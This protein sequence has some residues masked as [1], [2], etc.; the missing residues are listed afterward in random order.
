MAISS[1]LRIADFD[2]IK[3]NTITNLSC[4]LSKYMHIWND[5]KKYYK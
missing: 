4:S 2:Y 5:L 1:L 3:F